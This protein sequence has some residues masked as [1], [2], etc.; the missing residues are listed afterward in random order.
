VASPRQVDFVAQVSLYRHAFRHWLHNLDWAE[1]WRSAHFDNAEDELAYHAKILSRMHE[2]GWNRYGWPE[3]AGGF[4]G[5]EL[6]RAAYFEEL[7]AAM[8][9]VPEQHWTLEVI[10]PAVH[11]YAPHLAAEHLPGYLRGTEWWGQCFSEPESGSD[12][13]GLR[14]RA[15]DDG[16]GGFILNGQKIWTSQGPTATRFLLLARTGP[17]ESRHRGL[18]TFLVDADTPG[19]T[20]RP[21][22]LASG[23]R[24]LAEVY[25]DDVRIPRERLIG[26]VDGGWAVVMYL[27]QYERGMYGYAVT[28]TALTELGRLRAAM[29]TYGAS[30]AHRERF[31]QIYVAVAAA[32]ARG[33]TTVRALAE[34][35]AVGPE[36]SVDKLLFAKAEKDINDFILDV[37][38]EWMI[39]GAAPAAT[40]NSAVGAHDAKELDAARAKWWYT[41]AAT[42][43]GGSAEVQRGIIA[44]HILGLPKEKR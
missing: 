24:E 43:M 6:H 2:A 11:R 21:I 36:S 40:S 42:I 1:E 34:G 13:A 35:R 16:T 26:N 30:P 27:M 15:T 25:F 19:V 17:A 3:D 18:S 28:T 20:V 31:A 39:T 32:Q 4:G 23:R 38:R 29:A 9:P 22:T 8:L 14:C 37:R 33:A 41:R 12:L 44:D 7:A 10:G 5:S